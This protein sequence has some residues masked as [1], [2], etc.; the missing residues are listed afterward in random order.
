MRRVS[1]GSAHRFLRSI[2]D[3]MIRIELSTPL[4]FEYEDVSRRKRS[5]LGLGGG[6]IDAVLDKPCAL[7]DLHTDDLMGRPCLSDAGDDMVLKLAVAA[8]AGSAALSAVPDHASGRAPTARRR[9]NAQ[10]RPSATD[11]GGAEG[12]SGSRLRPRTGATPPAR[13]RADRCFGSSLRCGPVPVVRVVVR[14]VSAGPPGDSLR[15]FCVTLLSTVKHRW[16]V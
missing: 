10:G 16:T 13:G 6:D 3:R 11:L 1:G 8:R 7:A 14:P 2:A 4:L 12:P 5:T 15:R 9:V